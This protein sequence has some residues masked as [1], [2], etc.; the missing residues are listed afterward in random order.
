M[1]GTVRYWNS[2][3]GHALRVFESHKGW[4]T[5]T[6][7]SAD[8]QYALSGADDNMVRL[9]EIANRRTPIVLEGHTGPVWS[10]AFSVDSRHALSGSGDRTIRY[11]EIP[12]GTCYVCLKVI[13]AL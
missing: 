5:S 2:F 13:P 9:W 10:T 12:T 6:A 8:G 11:W 7:L 4:A 1:D 3:T